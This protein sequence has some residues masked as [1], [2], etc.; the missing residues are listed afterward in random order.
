MAVQ[1]R[2]TEASETYTT[3]WTALTRLHGVLARD[4]EAETGLPFEWYRVLLMLAQSDDRALRPSE[5]ADALPIT[6][7]GVTRLIDRLEGD[8]IVERRTCATDGRGRL[9]ALTPK[10][11]DVF[12]RAGRK[13]LSDIG[14]HLGSS[15]STDEMAQLRRLAGKLAAGV[16]AG[17]QTPVSWR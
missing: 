10:G 17:H 11:E 2:T 12:R 6:R 9:V 15:M 4:M 8:G 5:L 3:L 14:L 16:D 13:H 1:L 7:S